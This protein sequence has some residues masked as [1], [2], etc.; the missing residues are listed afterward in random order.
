MILSGEP[1]YGNLDP[2]YDNWQSKDKLGVF[3][4]MKT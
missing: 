1:E 4:E 2:R 3:M